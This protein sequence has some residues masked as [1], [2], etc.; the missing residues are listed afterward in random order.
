MTA[1]TLT[2]TAMIFYTVGEI[3]SKKY[4]NTGGHYYAIFAVLMYLIVS[5]LWLPTL[6]AKNTIAIIGTIWAIFY[7]LVA[8]LLGIFVFKEHL[9]IYNY[10]GVFLGLGSIYLL[11]R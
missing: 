9:S 8:V 3:L 11:C 10:V 7:S 6:Q 1:V 2:A 4:A 5:I